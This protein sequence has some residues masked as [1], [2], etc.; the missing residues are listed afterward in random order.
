MVDESG[1]HGQADGRRPGGLEPA[2]QAAAAVEVDGRDR[3]GQAVVS[4]DGAEG[5]VHPYPRVDGAR[6]RYLDV[7]G[8]VAAAPGAGGH[9]LDPAP[10]ARPALLH[11]DAVVRQRLPV[12]PALLVD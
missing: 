4:G 6:A 3:V 10:A 8:T 11:H 12:R 2:E 5:P 1:G 7:V 9:A